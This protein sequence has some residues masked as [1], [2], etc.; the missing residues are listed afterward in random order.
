MRIIPRRES[1][2]NYSNGLVRRPAVEKGEET[3][4]ESLLRLGHDNFSHDCGAGRDSCLDHN[5]SQ[6]GLHCVGAD[7]HPIRNLLAA[8]ALQQVLQYLSLALRKVVYLRDLRQ[9]KQSGGASFKQDGYAGTR[10]IFC[11]GI[12]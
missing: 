7:V 12:H 2:V 1:G 10:R 9:R 6:K 8:Q 11:L 3:K 5:Q 4:I